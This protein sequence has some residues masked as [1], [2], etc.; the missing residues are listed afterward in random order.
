MVGRSLLS[1]I[2]ELERTHLD[3]KRP[4]LARARLV[5]KGASTGKEAWA[6]LSTEGLVPPG[7]R[8]FR[9]TARELTRDG[10]RDNDLCQINSSHASPR[11]LALA[12]PHPATPEA[13][14][15]YA[16]IDALAL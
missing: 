2:T 7:D 12:L 1:L 5:A 14:I 10:R 4:H 11:P 15:A 13:A 16:S 8:L 3:P 9:V 6:R